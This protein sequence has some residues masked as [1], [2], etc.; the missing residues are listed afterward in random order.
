MSMPLTSSTQNGAIRF[1]LDGVVTTIR[2]MDPN[3][4]VL[5]FLR[6]ELHRTG[7]KEGCAEGDC[8]A[9]TVVLSE[10]YGNRVRYR[11]INSCIQF[12]PTLDGKELI[13]VE[14]LK[15]PDGT[16]HP[17]QRAMVECHGS[18][19][20]FCTPGIVMSLFALYKS[21][22]E[23]SR[24]RINDALAGNLCR[25]TGYRPVIAAAERMHRIGR[26]LADEDQHWMNCSFSSSSDDPVVGER[27]AYERLRS[28]QR[29]ETLAYTG[30]AL[31][32]GERRYHAPVDVTELAALVKRHEDARIL[33]GGTDIG[34]WVTK[35]HRDLN[36]II[37][38]GDVKTLKQINV[39]GAHIE[40]GAAVALSDVSDVVATYY[41]DMGEL[42]RRFGSPPIRNAAT[43]AGNIANGS[44]IG[45]SMP[46][47]IALG[48][49][50]ILRRGDETREIPLDE[51]YL[52]YQQTALAQGEFVERVRIP[53]GTPDRHFRVY[54][55]SK[56]FDQD[57][58]A[59][60]GAYCVTLD[61]NTVRD[62]R[63]CYGGMAPIPLRATH[64]EQALLG[65]E[66]N[67]S[68][69]T[70]ALSALD[71][72]YT[73]IS[74]MRATATYRQ[75]VAKNLLRKFHLETT[76]QLELTR[77]LNYEDETA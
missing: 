18:Q 3:M 13:T 6:D 22:R 36:T 45:D 35:G 75:H 39:T 21:E 46:G 69:V 26:E 38:V 10:L 72:D 34:L 53:L 70:D 77:V 32:G 40:V 54:K 27:E 58:A 14:N 20:G 44:P 66:W 74:D 76:G 41:P 2:D 42:F 17:V 1:V 12:L 61:G 49:T 73:P 33:A 51:F 65:K 7:T 67:E 63:I 4:T 5:N 16:L 68:S 50:L 59:V 9:C 8:G 47:L 55:I 64:C 24:H 57:I 11:A 23:P 29:R 48:T 31:N 19:C 52:G 62:V 60:C 43:L 30:P 56:R 37:Y 15:G 71:K 25:C 28:I